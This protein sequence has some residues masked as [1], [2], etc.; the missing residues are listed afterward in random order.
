[1]GVDEAP[2]IAIDGPSGA[3]KGTIACRLARRLGFRVLDSG[4]LY[5][6]LALAA[7]RCGVSLDDEDELARLALTLDVDFRVS[8]DDELIEPLM[9]GES[10]EASVRSQRCAENASRLAVFARVRAALLERQRAFRGPPGLV[11]DGRDM[12]TVV[13]PDA[14]VKI[15]LNASAEERAQR[16]YKQL[17]AKGIGVNLASL[18]GEISARDKRDRERTVAPLKPASDAGIIYTT[19]LSTDAVFERVIKIAG[20]RGVSVH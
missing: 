2:V 19:E 4:A 11:A 9:A 8:P 18:R 7:D 16:R 6:L 15:Y 17:I 10:V 5:R 3:G 12:G 1:V 20:A 13:F 14:V